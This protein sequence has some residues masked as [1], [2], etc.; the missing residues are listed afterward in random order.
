MQAPAPLATEAADE[1]R[2]KEATPTP[3][4]SDTPAPT[5]TASSTPSATA[6]GTPTPAPTPVPE[7]EAQAQ[8]GPES[9]LL[10]VVLL[11][12][13]GVLLVVALVVGLRAWRSR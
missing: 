6:T 9:P 2:T 12:L 8:A 13:S 7:D 5:L 11:A 1:A 3:A 10:G 4:P